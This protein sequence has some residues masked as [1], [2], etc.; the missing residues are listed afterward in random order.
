MGDI[1]TAISE[2]ATLA[3]PLSRDVGDMHGA[4]PTLRREPSVAKRLDDS[5]NEYAVRPGLRTVGQQE[6][7]QS[8]EGSV[9]STTWLVMSEMRRMTEEKSD[10]VTSEK[11]KIL[12]DSLLTVSVRM[13]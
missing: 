9:E 8:A 4:P 11:T 12:G 1:T 10:C 7:Q 2:D 5:F 3:T 13:K 6:H